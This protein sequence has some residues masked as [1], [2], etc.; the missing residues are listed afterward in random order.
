M[1]SKESA[2]GSTVDGAQQRAYTA[3]PQNGA[4]GHCFCAQVFGPDGKAVLTVEP[5]TDEGEASRIAEVCA[6]A[7]SKPA[8]DREADRQRFP[9]PLFNK[10]LDEGIADGYTAWDALSST[11]DAKAGWDCRASYDVQPCGHPQALLLRSAETSE[12]LYCEACDDK[13]GRRD[14]EAM[15]AAL[16][17]S[18]VAAQQ[19]GWISLPALP[20]P[21]MP[22]LLD[23][24]KKY[25][26]RAMWVE[27]KSLPVGIDSSDDFGEY[28]EEADDY[29]CPAGWYEWNESEE[30]H[31]RV[32]AEP[33]R[34]MLLP[35]AAAA[36]P[37]GYPECSGDPASCP[38][39]EGYGC[40]KPNPEDR[41][42]CS[43]CHGAGRV[44]EANLVHV[45]EHQKGPGHELLWAHCEAC[46]G[47][48]EA[49]PSPVVEPGAQAGRE[50]ELLE[51]ILAH[52]SSAK[53]LDMLIDIVH[54][55]DGFY[56]GNAKALAAIDAA[57]AVQGKGGSDGRC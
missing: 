15:E 24:G 2:T 42:P 30:T 25:P 9:D 41:A 10:W 52:L 51:F 23:I 31:F 21:Q 4:P 14:A 39:N 34:W 53:R 7:L 22:V 26:I 38:E 33:L 27:A 56:V 35:G 6:Q 50:A 44:E 46:D 49:A 20:E 12:P 19:E 18:P 13:S 1:G 57:C 8:R 16:S 48:G 29:F 17:P 11:G 36:A 40:C 5:T 43:A 37:E 45:R 28:D 32:T 54:D 55:E 3:A 47:T